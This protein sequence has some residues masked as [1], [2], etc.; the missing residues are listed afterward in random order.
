MPIIHVLRIKLFFRSPHGQR[1]LKYSM[2]HGFVNEGCPDRGAFH[3]RRR[4]DVC[5]IYAS[6]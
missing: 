1:E 3:S 4:R 6:R 2:A 5:G